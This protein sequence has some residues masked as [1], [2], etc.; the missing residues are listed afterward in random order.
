MNAAA[1]IEIGCRSRFSATN[2]LPIN[3]QGA[4]KH[5][6]VGLLTYVLGKTFSKFVCGVQRIF[7]PGFPV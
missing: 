3:A 1:P 5:F 2:A 7:Y 6:S 4:E